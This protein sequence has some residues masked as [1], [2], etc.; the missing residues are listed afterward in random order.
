VGR[1]LDRDGQPD[2]V[3]AADLLHD[4]PEN[5]VTTRTELRDLFGTD[6]APSV[7]SLSSNPSVDDTCRCASARFACTE[8][9]L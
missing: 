8:R 9:G 7:E 5:T 1:L 6:I 3:S 2:E 4:L